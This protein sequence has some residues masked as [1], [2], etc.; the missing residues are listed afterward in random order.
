MSSKKKTG[1]KIDELRHRAEEIERERISQTPENMEALS[2]EAARRMLNELQVHQIELEMQ[3]E[4]LRRTK[5]EL[6]RVKHL[7]RRFGMV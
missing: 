6:R 4:E 5:N 7:L 2:P 3:N 1:I